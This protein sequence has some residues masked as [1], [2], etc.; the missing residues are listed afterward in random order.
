MTKSDDQA[1]GNAGYRQV[2]MENIT[3]RCRTLPSMVLR[4]L[5]G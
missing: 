1:E 5:S 4:A 2:W 3:T